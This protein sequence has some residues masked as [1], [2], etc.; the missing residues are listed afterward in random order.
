[1]VLQSRI[2]LLN[3]LI[4]SAF[5]QGLQEADALERQ[6]QLY[7]LQLQNYI[8]KLQAQQQLEDETRKKQLE[9]LIGSPVEVPTFQEPA[10]TQPTYGV[11][12]TKPQSLEDRLASHISLGGSA[13][14]PVNLD[15]Y[16]LGKVGTTTEYTGGLLSD[17]VNQNPYLRDVIAGTLY[18]LRLPLPQVVR[19]KTGVYEVNPLTGETETIESVP[20]VKFLKAIDLGDKVIP[21]LSV[22]GVPTVPAEYVKG[23]SPEARQRFKQWQKEYGL[24][25]KRL[26][27]DK[28]KFDWEKE[29]Q[30]TQLG[31]KAQQ[32]ELQEEL[33]GKNRSSLPIT[34]K[35]DYIDKAIKMRLKKYRLDISPLFSDDENAAVD[36]IKKIAAVNPEDAEYIA[37]LYEKRKELMGQLIQQPVKKKPT[38]FLDPKFNAFLEG[39]RLK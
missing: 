34:K 25:V 12:L 23:L 9:D 14:F 6:K 3:N 38:K 39:W 4:S 30:K 10:L 17:L 35:L 11:S 27:L 8:K 2:G 19:G 31:L 1:M 15:N 16:S 13:N 5:L 28:Q 20:D 33:Q 22:N 36:V 24:K 32:L 29:Y 7:N 37:K 18:G 26:N 21:L